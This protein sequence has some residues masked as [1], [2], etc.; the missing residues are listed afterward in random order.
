MLTCRYQATLFCVMIAC[1]AGIA[2]VA[3][4]PATG[5]LAIPKL[6]EQPKVALL[7]QEGAGKLYQVE[8]QLLLVMEGTPAEMGFQHGRLLA[9]RIHHIVKEGYMAKAFYARG[10][11]LEY[12]N[13]QS[14]RME[15]HFPP[16]YIEEM[17]GIVKGLQAAGVS[18][19]NYE[20]IRSAVTQAEIAHHPANEPPE[21]KTPA[22][23]PPPQQCSN[24]AVWGKWTKD[25][26]LL[27]G[28]NLD[29]NI[30]GG[31]QEDAVLLVW[32]PATGI[33]FM[34]LGWSGGIASVSG[35]NAQG[36]TI[37]EMTSVSTDETFDGLPLMLMMRRVLET[38]ATLDE[39]VA[40]IQKGPRTIGWNFVIGD[41][42]IPGARALEVDAA[43]CTVF[44]PMDPKE[45]K[46][47]G[48]WAMEDAIRRTNHPIGM[49]QLRKLATRFGAQYGIDADHIQAAIPLLQ[50][51]D[52]WQRY[53]W[54]GKR[55]MER[56]G[57]MGPVDA[58]CLLANKPVG[59]DTTDTLHSF[60][61]D[62]FRKTAYV[63]VAATNPPVP[64]PLTQFVRI[65]LTEYFKTS[66]GGSKR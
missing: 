53:D 64:A 61:F 29:W 3:Q 41:G 28:R 56:P 34:M 8:G 27:H 18:D 20:E 12:I 16:E 55:I 25:G 46:E 54:L 22:T 24:F 26:H 35:M 47:T 23:T 44:G 17:R 63:A 4:S 19:I 14:E 31:A 43:D 40:V 33:P 39:A 58:M 30:D 36:I 1:A 13:A 10:Y 21:F 66:A 59:G 49:A 9:K 65:D 15:K 57:Q 2:A 5:E 38:A 32:H 7:D 6:I 11:T 62:P 48:H 37:G 45:G 50:L 51:Q 42:K 52:T 60:V